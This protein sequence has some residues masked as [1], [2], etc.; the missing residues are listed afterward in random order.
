MKTYE[1][2][3][4]WVYGLT[5]SALLWGNTG[6]GVHTRTEYRNFSSK[7]IKYDLMI[8]RKGES[9]EGYAALRLGTIEGEGMNTNKP[10]I[11]AI[12]WD[13]DYQVDEVRRHNMPKGHPFEALADTSHLNALER[14]LVK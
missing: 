14:A 6:C 9:K 13:M 1:K 8:E 3:K 4:N 10:L 11:Y 12:D 7:G 2:I 5:I